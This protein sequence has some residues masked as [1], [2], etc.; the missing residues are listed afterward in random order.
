MQI[1][2]PVL[3][4][5]IL[6]RILLSDLQVVQVRFSVPRDEKSDSSEDVDVYGAHDK[7]DCEEFFHDL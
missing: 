3:E 7:A 4:G 5:A 6:S 2:F 1:L